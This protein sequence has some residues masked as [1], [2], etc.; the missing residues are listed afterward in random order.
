MN[1]SNDFV[2]YVLDL[3]EPLGEVN[4]SRM[5]GGVLMKVNGKQLGVLF[6]D[7]VYFKVI[8][9]TTQEQYKAQGSRQFTYTRN[10]KKDPV[11]IRNWWSV[12]GSAMDNSDEIVKLAK[13]VLEQQK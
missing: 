7:T 8:N 6:G 9:K 11:I 4:T 3:L 5:F 1:I 12:P 10:D 2:E 13:K